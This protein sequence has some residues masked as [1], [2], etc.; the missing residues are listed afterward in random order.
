MA[1]KGIVFVFPLPR[2]PGDPAQ[3]AEHLF[4]LLTTLHRGVEPVDVLGELE[5][6]AFLRAWDGDRD[7]RVWDGCRDPFRMM[8]AV[9]AAGGLNPARLVGHAVRRYCDETIS[10]LEGAD[11]FEHAGADLRLAWLKRRTVRNENIQEV[12]HAALV[13]R[14][15]LDGD[16]AAAERLAKLIRCYVAVAPVMFGGP[17]PDGELMRR[18]WVNRS[19]LDPKD[20]AWV[21]GL[22]HRMART[23]S[24]TVPQRA[25]AEGLLRRAGSWRLYT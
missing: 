21:D 5:G 2:P 7:Q 22:R 15:H 8:E 18:L 4:H 10:E 13:A 23:G 6:L 11:P 25:H 3:K 12:I 9:G 16:Q 19:I 17:L 1:G 24:M 14:T 20:G